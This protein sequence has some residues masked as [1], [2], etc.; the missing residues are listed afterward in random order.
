VRPTL[1]KRRGS[2]ARGGARCKRRTP[3]GGKPPGPKG[4]RGSK[5]EHHRF[6]SR[7]DEA[8]P[9]PHPVGS[10]KGGQVEGQRYGANGRPKTSGEKQKRFRDPSYKLGWFVSGEGLRR[11]NPPDCMP[12]PTFAS[13]TLRDPRR[14][15]TG[16]WSQIRR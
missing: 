15:I 9:S 14:L 16:N 3:A 11:R 13:E 12:V 5:R 10:T 1:L 8:I 7:V 4:A 2:R 6:G